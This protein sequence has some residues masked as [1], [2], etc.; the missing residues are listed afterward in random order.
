MSPQHLDGAI[1]EVV[2]GGVGA[3]S[4]DALERVAAAV[5]TAT[6]WLQPWADPM[7]RVIAAGFELVGHGGGRLVLGRR[8]VG[9]EWHADP[10]VRGP[11]VLRGF[12]RVL[13]REV[14]GVEH[15]DAET[16][17]ALAGRLLIPTVMAG[18]ARRDPG[19]PAQHAPRAFVARRIGSIC[20]TQSGTYAA[21]SEK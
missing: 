19:Q 20:C 3:A 18:A 12:A 14:L 8:R 9:F 13:L 2:V 6:A 11:R 7:H 1:G 10:Q 5:F 4:D 15:P 21:V 17:E 16:V